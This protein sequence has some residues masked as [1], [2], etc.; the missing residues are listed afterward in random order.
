[1]NAENLRLRMIPP[2]S[3]TNE[4]ATEAYAAISIAKPALVSAPRPIKNKPKTVEEKDHAE[5]QQR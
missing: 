1:M 3:I 2:I 4:E 5:N